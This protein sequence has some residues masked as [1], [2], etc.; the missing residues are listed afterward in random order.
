MIVHRAYWYWLETRAEWRFYCCVL[1]TWNRVFG[2]SDDVD[3]QRAV[4]KAVSKALEC[5]LAY[6][7]V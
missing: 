4:D 7:P 1:D 3:P 6:F 5:P 2:G